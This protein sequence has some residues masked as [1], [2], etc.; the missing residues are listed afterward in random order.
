MARPAIDDPRLKNGF[1]KELTGWV[2]VH[3]QG[4]PF[5]IG[6]Q[7]GS[8]LAVEIDDA[9]KALRSE[10]RGPN[11]EGWDW[12]RAAAKEIMWD[13]VD[14]EYQQ[15]IEGQAAGLQAKG[16]KYDK[17]D[18]LAYNANIELEGYYA[19]YLRAKQRK[20]QIESGSKESCSA[21]VATG[22]AT[23]DGKIVLGHNLW[24]G[25]LMGERANVILDIT[26]QKGQ[27]V[28][29]DAFCGML[30]SG[31][32]FAINSAGMALCETTISGFAGFDPK[33][34][35][36][37]VRMRRAIQYS[38]NLSE[39]VRIF[40]TGNNGG[41][42]NTWLM[43]DSKTNEIGKL[44]LGLKNVIYSSTTDG[45]FVG[46]NFPED[47]KLIREE[48]PGGWNADPKRN[49][50]ERRKVRWCSLLDKNKGQVDAEA[51][52]AFLA[53]TYDEVLDKQGGSGSTL[54]GKGAFGGAVNTKVVTG[55]MVG[56]LQFWARMGVS[57]GSPKEFP[58]TTN[59][60]LRAIPTYP[61][62]LLDPA[63]LRP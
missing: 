50:S 32:D 63:T 62:I 26:P 40:K 45:Y 16:Y 1:R 42:A 22:S 41:Y 48:V 56:K 27:R 34:I 52:K 29:F 58:N 17:W 9:H 54:C 23:K 19:P 30:H 25:Y 20:T 5:D 61:W 39:M 55:D 13:K 51:G 3:L 35:P 60:L 15:E 37:F 10:A 4:K 33:G 2:Y 59:P 11:G 38:T 12:Y 6:F 53:D 24:W 14:P 18:V 57:D 43:A 21:F 47:P 46:A 36:E 44:E 31:T 28:L 7:Y 8:L 49:G